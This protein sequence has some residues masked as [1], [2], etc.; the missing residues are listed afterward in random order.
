MAAKNPYSQYKQNSIMT[1]SP[2]ELNLMLYDGLLKFLKKAMYAIDDKNIQEAHNSITRTQDII[3]Q[4]MSVVDQ[5]YEIG[6][7]LYSLYD[8]MNRR[9]IEANIKKDKEILQ[10]VYDLVKEL[11][12]TWKEGM[13]I[14]KKGK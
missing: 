10:E 4:F 5:S 6:Q 13:E 11:R 8:F 1:A 2:Q 9:L 14:A 12:D 3:F 7:N